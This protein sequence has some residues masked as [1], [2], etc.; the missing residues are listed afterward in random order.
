MIDPSSRI[1]AVIPEAVEDLLVLRNGRFELRQIKTRNESVGAW[2][3][4]ELVPILATQYSRSY[5]FG[6]RRFSFHFVSDARADT[7]APRGGLG[8]LER[9]KELLNLSRAGEVLG[10]TERDQLDWFLRVLPARLAAAIS[11]PGGAPCSETEAADFL[12]GTYVE[13]NDADCRAPR[14]LETID[15]ALERA[16]PEE[17][18]RTVPELRDIYDR[19]LLMIVQ[20]IRTGRDLA[21]RAIR[22]ADVIGCRRVADRPRDEVLQLDTLPG[23]TKLEKKTLYGGFSAVEAKQFRRQM[24]YARTRRRE[25]RAMGLGD[26]LELLDLALSELQ[27]ERRRFLSESDSVPFPFGPALLGS[28]RPHLHSFGPSHLPPA[29]LPSA[30]LCQGLLWDDTQA[31]RS[32]WHPISREIRIG[33]PTIGTDAIFQVIPASD[34]PPASDSE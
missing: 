1:R 17:P 14:N 27:R 28:L 12:L 33:E 3:T 20:R 9:L 13:T 4:S 23:A 6:Q 5:A 8:S 22:R 16:L 24:A 7:R 29:A 34:P 32:A 18:R 26:E 25:L 2:S 10:G 11:V 21:G 30:M 31:C 15:L 19:L